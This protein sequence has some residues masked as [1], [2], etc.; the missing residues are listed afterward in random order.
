MRVAITGASGFIGGVLARTLAARGHEVFAYGR[1]PAGRL[2]ASIPNYR[3]WDLLAATPAVPEVD[4]VIHCAAKIGDWGR[5]ED[6]RSVNVEG[7]RKV[8]AVFANAPRFV[9]VSSASVYSTDQP[10]RHLSED[11]P[12]GNGLLTAYARSKAEAE[13]V[14]LASGRKAVILRP[15]VVYGPGDPTLMPRL[16]AAPRFGWLAVPGNGRN[17]ISVTHVF[18]FAQAAERAVTGPVMAGVFNIA[19]AQTTAIDELLITLLRKNGIEV[20][21]LHVPANMAWALAVASEWLWRLAGSTR[22]PRLTRY[23]VAQVADAHTLDLT[24]AYAELGYAPRH[25]IHSGFDIGDFA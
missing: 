9:H 7:T 5:D 21:L 3:Q 15:H 24:R 13:N 12:T 23:L 2:P 10:G 14:L 22:A 17:H 8:I 25:N 4:A 19:D 11:A 1:R 16:L 6:Y 20:R 18:N